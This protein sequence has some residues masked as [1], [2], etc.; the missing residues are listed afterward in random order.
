MLVSQRAWVW[1]LSLGASYSL[2]RYF[3]GN[4]W[5]AADAGF[6]VYL[7]LLGEY[8]MPAI[9]GLLGVLSFGHLRSRTLVPN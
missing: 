9:G 6:Y 5:V 1:G 3:L 8:L 4:N 2:L 7:A